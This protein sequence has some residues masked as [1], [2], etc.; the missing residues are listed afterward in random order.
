MTRTATV[1]R[2]TGETDIRIELDL[3]GTGKTD[4]DTGV[5]LPEL[6]DLVEGLEFVKKDLYPDPEEAGRDRPGRKPAAGASHGNG[7]DLHGY[8]QL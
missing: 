6:F 1:C 5:P 7:S 4:I 8:G 2:T 3:D